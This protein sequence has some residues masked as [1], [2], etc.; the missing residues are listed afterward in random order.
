MKFLQKE[1]AKLGNAPGTIIN[2]SM[3]IIDGDPNTVKNKTHLPAG[4][5]KCDGAIY[6]KAL[7]PNLASMLGTGEASIY[8]KEGTTLSEDQ[9][10]VPDLGSKHIQASAAGNVGVT[11]DHTRT[12]GTGA[13]ST[14]VKKAGVGVNINSNVG[15]QA[16]V[17]FNGVF[18]VPQ[19]NFALNGNIGWTIPTVT[20]SETVSATAFG[21]HMHRTSIN[22]VAVK[23]HPAYEN[24]SRPSY[25]RAQDINYTGSFSNPDCNKRAL[26][27][28]QTTYDG[29]TYGSQGSNLGK[30]NWKCT[31]WNKYYMGYAFSNQG[32]SSTNH[33]GGTGG[34][35]AS[36]TGGTQPPLP[37][38]W[39]PTITV[40]S[41]T[42]TSWPNVTTINVGEAWA[43]DTRTGDED[44]T[45][46]EWP[47]ARNNIDTTET[48][49]GSETTDYTLH[50]HRIEREYGT[51]A[52][53]ATTDVATVRPDGLVAD[54]NITTT[55]VSKFDDVVS[56]YVVLEY[57]IKF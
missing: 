15:T 6:N 35:Q 54:V 55:N 22:Y 50:S 14:T 1:R 28:Y 12:T 32:G 29:N 34:V 49:P 2:W 47:A 38:L 16:T 5:L 18:T 42:A 51:T 41:Y 4:Y 31:D 9:F 19:Q 57:L 43:Y 25:L 10:Q 3:P 56:P 23:D 24:L 30:C 33:P 45:G 11:Q 52:Y 44:A 37:G 48:P 8:K 46:V 27:Y 39:N 13:N 17:Q 26:E 40:D 36:S 21:S 53:Q 20:E 7:Y